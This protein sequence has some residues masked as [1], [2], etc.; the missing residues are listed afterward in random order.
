[1]FR[2]FFPRRGGSGGA[3]GAAELRVSVFLVAPEPAHATQIWNSRAG[4]FRELVGIA[5]A[6]CGV[7]DVGESVATVQVEK[8]AELAID[9]PFHAC[10]SAAVL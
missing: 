6:K 4:E 2:A 7:A 3:L 10:Q 1:M 8:V 5:A 9:D